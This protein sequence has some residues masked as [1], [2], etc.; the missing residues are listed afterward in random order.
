[1]IKRDGLFS[2][3]SVTRSDRSLHTPSAFARQNLLYV[4]EVGRL[5]SLTPHRCIR[6]NLDSFLFLVVLEGK[7][8]LDIEGK[9]YEIGKGDC[10]L[11][12]CMKHYE[13]ISDEKEAWKLAW[14]HFNGNAA[15]GYYEL[16]MKY[17]GGVNVF[18]TNETSSWDTLIG[19]LRDV[20]KEKNLQAELHCGELLMKLLNS[21][22]DSVASVS[23]IASEQEKQIVNE[24]RELL[25]EKYAESDVLQTVENTLGEGL[26]ELGNK[27]ANQFGISIEEYI[28]NRRFNASK[29]MLRFS[30]RPV[31]E[32][33]KESGIG[34]M[35][36]M[37]QLFC[38]NEG[39]TVEEYRAKWAAWIR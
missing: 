13:H 6:E 25:N 36:T 26:Q 33:A 14:V 18:E 16:F 5:E 28:S 2:E 22:I 23:V 24:L 38:E 17:N 10:A 35:I 4:Q 8:S 11:I 21:I 37:Q 9:H 20:Q 31:E 7:G 32:V 3:E 34:D 30:I 39:M 15:R 12:D 1:M 29:E 19:A 27:F